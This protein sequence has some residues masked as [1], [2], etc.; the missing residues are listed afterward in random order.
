MF[1][2]NQHKIQLLNIN[3]TFFANLRNKLE[4][5]FRKI[6]KFFYIDIVHKR[7]CYFENSI[8]KNSRDY[9]HKLNH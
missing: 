7:Q 8:H 3:K 6:L 5:I 2:I 9:T 4:T 1:D